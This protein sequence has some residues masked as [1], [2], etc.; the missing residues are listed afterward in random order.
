VHSSR[1]SAFPQH[2]LFTCRY[3]G[4]TCEPGV[5]PRVF[6]GAVVVVPVERILS[7]KVCGKFVGVK[8]S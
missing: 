6:V 5:H 2:L 3:A 8:N 1:E 7:K 4:E